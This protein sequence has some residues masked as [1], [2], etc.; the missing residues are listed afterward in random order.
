MLIGVA[1]CLAQRLALAGRVLPDEDDL[2]AVLDAA[3][4]CLDKFA[5]GNVSSQ[6]KRKLMGNFASDFFSDMEDLERHDGLPIELLKSVSC[7]GYGCPPIPKASQTPKE[8]KIPKESK[9]P[10]VP[11][12]KKGRRHASKIQGRKVGGGM[13]TVSDKELVRMAE[14]DTLVLAIIDDHAEPM[15]STKRGPGRDS[16][17][18]SRGDG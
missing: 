13:K 10:K 9:T 1:I 11:K 17:G 16:P 15:S 4:K 8:P 2:E 18:F 14:I 12:E 6:G 7:S 3:D 5:D